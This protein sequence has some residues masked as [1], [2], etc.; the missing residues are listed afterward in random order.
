MPNRV[1]NC[2]RIVAPPVTDFRHIGHYELDSGG[3][4]SV[5]SKSGDADCSGVVD[6]DDVVYLIAYILSGGNAPCDTDGD[7]VPDC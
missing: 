3:P 7:T 2:S 1:V 5:P 4:E 6:I